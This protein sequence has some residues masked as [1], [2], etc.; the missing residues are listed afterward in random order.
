MAEATHSILGGK[1]QLYRRPNSSYWQ[2][3]A[4]VGGHQHRHSTKQESL[5]LAKDVAEDWF[6]TLKGKAARG[7]LKTGKT[8]RFAAVRFMAEFKVLTRGYRSPLYIKRHEERLALYLLGLLPVW[9]TP[10]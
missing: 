9:W 3:R 7:Q 8:F 2:C 5:A 4:S 1:V 10:R 6:L